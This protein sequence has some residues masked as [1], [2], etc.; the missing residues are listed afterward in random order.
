MN[1]QVCSSVQ[2]VHLFQGSGQKKTLPGIVADVQNSDGTWP[3]S[4]LYNNSWSAQKGTHDDT[5]AN[6]GSFKV[7]AAGV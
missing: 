2:I 1:P 6:V 4:V 7:V 3:I 5:L